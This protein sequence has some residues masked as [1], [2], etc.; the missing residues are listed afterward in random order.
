MDLQQD[1]LLMGEGGIGLSLLPPTAQHSTAQHDPLEGKEEEEEEEEGEEE[2]TSVQ[3]HTSQLL[4]TYGL[5][6][7]P[8]DRLDGCT[9]PYW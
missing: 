6:P 9:L 5:P 1:G 2:Q 4:Q 8:Q 3:P 7:L